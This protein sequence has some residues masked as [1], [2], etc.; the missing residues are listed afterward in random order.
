MG[1]AQRHQTALRV[2]SVGRAAAA[3]LLLA[4]DVLTVAVSEDV[5]HLD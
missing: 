3:E 2:V 4:G 5:V 1:P